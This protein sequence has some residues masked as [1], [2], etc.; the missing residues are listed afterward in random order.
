[1]W[2]PDYVESSWISQWM[3]PKP[4][5]NAPG[6]VNLLPRVL[7]SIRKYHPDTKIAITE[8]NY[9]EADHVTG[10]LANADFLGVLGKLGVFAANFWQLAEKPVYVA[11][12]IRLFRNYDGNKGTFASMS[13]AA[14]ASDKDNAS[15]FASY[16]P[17]GDEVHIIVINKNATEAIRGAFS[18]VSPVALTQ[19]KVFGFD[20]GGPALSEK[21]AVGA[22]TGN[23]FTYVLP[24]LSAH[25]FVIKTGAALP[26]ASLRN[27]LAGAGSG[28]MDAKGVSAYLPDGRL[29]P[30]RK[31]SRKPVSAL[32]LFIR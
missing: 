3:T 25:H 21:T 13:A 24:P 23:A 18:V 30:V 28:K 7:E 2:D 17:G 22:V 29:L 10:G 6:P 8:Y 27:P 31:D 12:A 26:A 32:P 15:V 11:S 1:L 19:G 9:G 5:G 14:A 20:G 16:V 4:P